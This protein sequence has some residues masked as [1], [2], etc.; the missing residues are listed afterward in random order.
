MNNAIAM[1][2]IE[3]VVTEEELENLIK[4]LTSAGVRGYSYIKEVGGLGSRGV[5]RPDDVIWEEENAIMILACKEDQ[6]EKIVDILRP[7]LKE[8]GGMCLVSDCL[9]IEGP[10]VSY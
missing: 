1:K 2:R 6:A 5:R 7:K 8:F 9:W 10:A 3:I 4:L